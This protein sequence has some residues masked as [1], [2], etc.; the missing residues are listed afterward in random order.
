MQ[1]SKDGKGIELLKGL[2]ICTFAYLQH[3]HIMISAH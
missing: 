2:S 1:R 3:L